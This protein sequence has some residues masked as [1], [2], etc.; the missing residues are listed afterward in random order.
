MKRISYVHITHDTNIAPWLGLVHPDS[1]TTTSTVACPCP[2]L[3]GRE[4]IIVGPRPDCVL[5]GHERDICEEP[6]GSV[7]HGEWPP[8]II[9]LPGGI[10][11]STT[12]FGMLINPSD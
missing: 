12:Y 4:N 7:S 2:P 9:R 8:H 5:Y 11:K 10:H 1:A 6:N 3:Q